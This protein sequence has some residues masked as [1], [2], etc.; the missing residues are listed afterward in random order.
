MGKNSVGTGRISFGLSLT[1]SI[2]TCYAST[3]RKPSWLNSVGM[4]VDEFC[5]APLKC[6]CCSFAI[7]EMWLKRKQMYI[8]ER[9]QTV[10]KVHES[11]FCTSLFTAFGLVCDCQ[12]LLLSQVSV[13]GPWY[14]FRHSNFMRASQLI[15]SIY[16]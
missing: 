6:P 13:D 10:L 4:A 3:L 11:I 2:A 9:F 5:P 14:F 12:H 8:L 15:Y 1:R 7:Q 16:E